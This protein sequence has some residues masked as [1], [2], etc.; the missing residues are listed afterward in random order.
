MLARLRPVWNKF[1]APLGEL[2]SKVG[3]SP[4]TWTL[5]SLLCSLV[6]SVYLYYGQFWMGL[7]WIIIML[8]ADMLD[9]A[10]A[11]ATGK[12]GKFGMVFDHVIDRYAEFIIFAG[13]LMGGWIPLF[14]GM[15]AISGIIMASYVRAKAES[16]GGLKD[17]T[18]GIAGRA[19]KI[20]LTYGAILFL[21]IGIKAWAEYFFIAIGLVSH[22]TAIQRL[23]YTKSK[24]EVEANVIG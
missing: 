5:F 8:I 24:I 20:L 15:F 13:L 21:A 23:L 14:T 18:V 22:V 1:I 12:A 7:I 16:A 11:R 3:I 10:T 2:S 6:G 19:E 9:G 17:C 4:N